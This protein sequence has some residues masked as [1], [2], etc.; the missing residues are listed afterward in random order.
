MTHFFDLSST[1]SMNLYEMVKLMKDG[2]SK[3]QP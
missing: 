2:E 3:R 1:L